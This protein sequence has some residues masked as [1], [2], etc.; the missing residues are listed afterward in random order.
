MYREKEAF[1]K[2]LLFLPSYNPFKELN[3]HL[4]SNKD[5]T[6]LIFIVDERFL[7]FNL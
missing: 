5:I 2:I 3:K 6:I 4:T 7:S 1:S